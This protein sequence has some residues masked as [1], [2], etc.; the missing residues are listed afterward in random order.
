MLVAKGECLEVAAS[1][2]VVALDMPEGALILG[3]PPIPRE[4]WRP[5]I[6]LAVYPIGI[7]ASPLIHERPKVQNVSELALLGLEPLIVNSAPFLPVRLRGLLPAVGDILTAHGFAGLDKGSVENEPLSQHLHSISGR[8]TE[9][10]PGDGNSTR[11]WPKVIVEAHWPSGMSGGPVTNSNGEVVGLVSTSFEGAEQSIAH[12]FAG[13]N[14]PESN[15]PG[16]DPNNPGWFQGFAAIDTED[17]LRFFG[18]DPW[19][20]KLFSDNHGCTISVVSFNPATAEWI[21]LNDSN[22]PYKLPFPG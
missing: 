4:W 3:A 12:L 14:V 5:L 2:A 21:A 7:K 1:V 8:V 10:V 16:L 22:G 13:W 15:L 20:V 11:P 19:E 6:G 17:S 9:V 18:H